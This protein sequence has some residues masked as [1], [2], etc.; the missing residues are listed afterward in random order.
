MNF[1]GVGAGSGPGHWSIENVPRER[2]CTPDLHEAMLT[3][4]SRRRL[5]LSAGY[6]TS[7]EIGPASTS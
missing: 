4:G 1:V 6:R 2:L 3:G 5:R 7:K